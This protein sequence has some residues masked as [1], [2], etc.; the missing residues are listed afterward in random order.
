MEKTTKFEQKTFKKEI[1]ICKEL[2]KKNNGKCNW[3]K[4]KDCGVVPLLHKLFLGKFFENKDEVK[5]IRQ[6]I[7][8]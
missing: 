5:K 6:K 8:G 3:G 2:S 1:A 4:C 7:L